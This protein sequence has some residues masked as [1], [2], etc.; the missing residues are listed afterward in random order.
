KGGTIR[1]VLVGVEIS[2]EGA[3]SDVLLNDWE[4]L[5][6]LNRV[7]NVR[8]IKARTSSRPDAIAALAPILNRA[9]FLVEQR[10]DSVGLPFRLPA[11]ETLAVLWP[12][13]DLDTTGR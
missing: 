8:G 13:S 10:L 11:I 7:S 9:R 2:A 1:A 6:R 5:E 12:A 4:L 3:D